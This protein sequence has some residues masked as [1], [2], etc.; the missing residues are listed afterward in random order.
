MAT[1]LIAADDLTGGA[2]TALAAW[3]HLGLPTRIFPNTPDDLSG[4]LSCG[5]TVGEEI[6]SCNLM[7]RTTPLADAFGWA[8]RWLADLGPV[9][10]LFWKMDSTLRGPWAGLVLASVQVCEGALMVV[11]PAV[12]SQG[13]STDSNGVQWVHGVPVALSALAQDPLT[14]VHESSIPSALAQAAEALGVTPP[15]VVLAADVDSLEPL[16]SAVDGAASGIVVLCPPNPETFRAQVGRLM[17]DA[18]RQVVW[19]GAAGLAEAVAKNLPRTVQ[20]ADTTG[21]PNLGDTAA[22]VVNGSVTP[23]SRDQVW[24]LGERVPG[25][26]VVTFPSWVWRGDERMVKCWGA[27]VAGMATGPIAMTSVGV[28]GAL[29]PWVTGPLFRERLG[30]VVS[31]VA[32][33]RPRALWVLSGGETV[34]A[35][36]AGLGVAW[37]TPRGEVAPNVP[38]LETDQGAWVV[39]KSGFFGTADTLYDVME[40]L[41]QVV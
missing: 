37:L 17:R 23:L 21:C 1:W 28:S 38:L 12:F 2:D 33:A 39:T 32:Q 30:W 3:R 9:G 5:A 41:G 16:L 34:A 7:L 24:R 14:P 15:P 8:C 22:V 13:R 35:A 20:P 36:M 25:M 11:A 31:A 10:R 4:V 26:T 6:V 27:T 40:K 18:R 29:N 19:A